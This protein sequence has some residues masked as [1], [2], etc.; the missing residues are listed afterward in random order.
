MIRVSAFC[1]LLLSGAA[2]TAAA[3]DTAS[4][5]TADAAP[6]SIARPAAELTSSRRDTSDPVV[7]DLPI[8]CKSGDLERASGRTL[9]QVFG[10][11][12]PAPPAI[13]LKKRAPAELLRAGQQSP[14]D[15][16]LDRGIVVSAVLVDPQGKPLEVQVL[17]ASGPG[18]DMAVRRVLV[19][20]RYRPASFEGLP[21]TGVAMVVMV[22]GPG[23][24]DH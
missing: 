9:G 10:A 13:A 20:G 17:C 2:A 3:P 4:A 8:R 1:A 6:A 16:Y 7:R 22:T 15:L 24:R 14:R 19:H 11:A 12:W 5:P 18:L 21:A 23:Q